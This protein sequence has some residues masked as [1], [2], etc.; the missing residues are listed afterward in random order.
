[1]SVLQCR[2][3]FFHI[4]VETNNR[5][6]LCEHI[7]LCTLSNCRFLKRFPARVPRGSVWLHPYMKKKQ[8]LKK[9]LFFDIQ[10][11][12]KQF[13][14]RTYHTNLIVIFDCLESVTGRH[15]LLLG[16]GGEG[17]HGSLS[18]KYTVG[19]LEPG[20][21][22]KKR[23]DLVR[24][25]AQKGFQSTICAGPPSIHISAGITLLFYWQSNRIRLLHINCCALF[26]IPTRSHRVFVGLWRVLFAKRFHSNWNYA[27]KNDR[28][29]RC[30]RFLHA[31]IYAPSS[32]SLRAFHEITAE[33][34]A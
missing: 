13:S 3:H 15:L 26:P 30:W 4:C 1:M 8:I 23:T 17:V 29:E 12:R 25:A 24:G 21:Y 5:P 18:D 31:I 14:A 33:L 34:C 7:C 9:L 28:P 22:W 27:P 11:D 16:I 2:D 20:F 6:S 19:C 10:V 32:L